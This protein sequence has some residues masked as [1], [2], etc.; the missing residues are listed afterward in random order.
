MVILKKS[1]EETNEI[2]IILNK[3]SSYNNSLSNK[4]NNKNFIKFKCLKEKCPYIPLLKYY[5]YTQTVS[6]ICR[7]NHQYHVPL[8]E[9]FEK[10]LKNLETPKYCEECMKK[11]SGQDGEETPEY[12]CTNCSFFL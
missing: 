1:K 7:N 8:S 2:K 6:A 5:E 12:F 10:I 4:N 9:Y 3:I 11:N